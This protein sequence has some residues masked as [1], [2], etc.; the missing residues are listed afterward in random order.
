MSQSVFD[1]KVD[2]A[3]EII[4]KGNLQVSDKSKTK[5][6]SPLLIPFISIT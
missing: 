5:G 4:L 6:K 2:F 3:V 1:I